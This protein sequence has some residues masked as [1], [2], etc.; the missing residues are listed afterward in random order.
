[1]DRIQLPERVSG[2]WIF[3]KRLQ[4]KAQ[5]DVLM[6]RSFFLEGAVQECQLLI[7]ANSFYRLFINGN[8][9]GAGPGP[10]QTPGI[11]FVDACEVGLYLQPGNN[12]ISVQICWA[13]DQKRGDFSRFPGMWCQLQCGNK[14]LLQSDDEWQI[15]VLE[16]KQLPATDVTYRGRR[17]AV[18]DLRQIPER[19]QLPEYE[20]D[21][22]WEKP[23]FFAPP[24]V[25]GAEMELQPVRPS[26]IN[27]EPFELEKVSSCSVERYPGFS[28]V[29]FT[30]KLQGT[31]CAAVSYVYCEE[32]RPFKVKVFADAPVKF[33][34]GKKRL[35]DETYADGKEIELPFA[36]GWNRLVIFMPVAKQTK[37]VLLLAD[38]WPEELIPL[39]DM[40]ESSAPGWCV[41]AVNKLEFG[42]CTAAVQVENLPGLLYAGNGIEQ[43]CH[44]WQLLE[45]TSFSSCSE[46]KEW[47][48]RNEGS[49]YKLP[50]IRY[51][52]ARVEFTA[53]AGDRVE[54]FIGTDT[55][56]N[57]MLPK[58]SRGSEYDVVSCICREG[59][60]ELQTTV[61]GDCRFIFLFV[62]HAAERVTV[63][64]M[65][66]DEL[67][68]N[69]DRQGSFRCSD[70]LLNHFWE[71]GLASLNRSSA[72]LF[73]ADGAEKHDLYLLDGCLESINIL[74]VFGEAAYG[75]A[76]LRQFAGTQLENGALTSLSSGRGYDTAFL[77]LF[78]LPTWILHNY[79]FS[80]NMVEMR[81]LIPCMDRVRSYLTFMMDE[82]EG[83]LDMARVPAAGDIESDP[84]GRCR[85]PAALNGLLCRFLLSASEIYD[86]VERPSD[87]RECRRMFRKVSETVTKRFF[88]EATGLFAN[89]PL[90]D[91]SEMEF[92]VLGNFFPLQAG[93]KTAECF[94]KFVKTFF[95]FDKAEPLTME[96]ESPYFHWPFSEMLFAL[97]QK[98]WGCAYFRRYWEKRMDAQSGV[99]RDPFRRTINALRFADGCTVVPNVTLIREILGVRIAEPAHS[100]I[101]FDPAWN[102]VEFAEA[103]LQ[104]VRGR[105]HIKWK[106]QPDGGLEVTMS[107]SFPVKVV[108]EFSEELLK[109]STFIL[110]ENVVLV[111]SAVK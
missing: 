110:G 25:K 106:K 109:Q 27:P 44:I 29:L 90:S 20:Y 73:P 68:R 96:A 35:L 45:H 16:E 87:A 71:L 58:G 1:M 69:F 62:R 55:D 53:R 6:R 22:G 28:H 30:G 23:D 86:L 57:G 36:S 95:D 83:L 34:C 91:N 72:L 51:G 81:T 18:R 70:T 64:N 13:P 78:F 67:H 32:P 76:R 48:S 103:S 26:E 31:A 111:K 24:G 39:S 80:G 3:L 5:A 108:P 92:S 14:T 43:V 60:N 9:V 105:I 99:W 97:G 85:I 100:V 59:H 12:V 40:M 63:K 61:P 107:A 49:L 47:L 89:E 15:L 21:P 7:S 104:T 10:H 2:Q 8:P 79:R 42:A 93:I 66:F 74:E 88:D 56:E 65:F 94:E 33:F 19:W 77:H 41:A 11:S 50:V 37:G 82:E 98:E 46:E 75:T 38:E 84:V 54:L 4:M 102:T 101:Y 17:T 52:F